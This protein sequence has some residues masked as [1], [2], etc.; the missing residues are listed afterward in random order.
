MLAPGIGASGRQ[1]E[2]YFEAFPSCK[3]SAPFFST[4]IHSHVSRAGINKS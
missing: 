1:G 2:G 4:P 3:L